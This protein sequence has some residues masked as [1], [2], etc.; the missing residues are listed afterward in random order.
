MAEAEAEIAT[1]KRGLLSKKSSIGFHLAHIW[2]ERFFELNAPAGVLRY[3]HSEEDADKGKWRKEVPFERFLTAVHAP[4]RKEGRQFYLHLTL[5]GRTYALRAE[6]SEE[7]KDWVARLAFHLPVK[8]RAAMVLQSCWRGFVVRRRWT[9]LI[10]ERR[11]VVEA[12][13]A[14]AA[15]AEAARK[16][17]QAAVLLQAAWRGTSARFEVMELRITHEAAT[18]L[19]A[20]WRGHAVRL[21]RA[22]LE[23]EE[24]LGLAAT[25]LQAAWRGYAERK[26]FD[27][28]MD[29]LL[30]AIEEEEAA[31]AAAEAAASAAAAGGGSGG[32]EGV[33]SAADVA[34][35]PRSRRRSRRRGS[36]KLLALALCVFLASPHASRRAIVQRLTDTPMRRPPRPLA[37]HAEGVRMVGDDA[38]VRYG[39]STVRRKLELSADIVDTW[40]DVLDDPEVDWMLLGH[41]EKNVVSVKHSGGG[42]LPALAIHLD[43]AHVYWIVFKVRIGGGD[44]PVFVTWVGERVGAMARGAVS[45]ESLAVKA[46]F[47]GVVAFAEVTNLSELSSD[48]NERLSA[49]VGGRT[50]QPGREFV[51]SGSAAD[52]YYKEPSGEVRGPIPEGDIREWLTAGI[53]PAAST[54]CRGDDGSTFLPIAEL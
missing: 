49:L 51:P 1:T 34:L 24:L 22:R 20:A 13:A 29:E 54:F 37:V 26:R 10:A 50:T 28:R 17:E 52:L 14:A 12:E 39:H 8:T 45:L 46:T 18:L 47:P 35:S 36:C 33:V 4:Y 3:A 9:A 38:D 48:L 41:V 15:E 42:G 43:D 6:T 40:D 16:R 21:H 31:A 25:M 2:Q 11:A 7:A 44:K 5:G 32:A 30:A 53:I 27:A 23:E 19:Q